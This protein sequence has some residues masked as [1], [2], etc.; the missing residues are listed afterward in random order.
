[1][2]QIFWLELAA[3]D[4]RALQYYIAQDK[5]RAAQT[6]AKKI[7]TSVHHLSENPHMDRVGRVV[8][9]R[10]LI[11]PNTPYILPYRIKN[12]RIEI[13]RVLHSSRKWPE[14]I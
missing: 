9:T 3:R 12:N 5:P 10:E 7:R 1:M 4:L 2:M 8:N 13:L 14:E 6:L 11:I